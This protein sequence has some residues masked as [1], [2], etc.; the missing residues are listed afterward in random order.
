MGH[1][2]TNGKA[3]RVFKGYKYKIGHLADVAGPPGT[4]A[5]FGAPAAM[6]S[7]PTA[8]FVRNHN[9]KPHG[10]LYGQ[11][12]ADAYRERRLPEG[13]SYKDDDG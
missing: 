6:E 10:S 4:A 7:D 2:Q 9:N 5:P 11:T 12:S 3:E 1:P 8:R 13:R